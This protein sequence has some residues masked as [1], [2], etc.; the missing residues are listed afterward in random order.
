[1]N[2]KKEK[3]YKL[4][5]IMML[6]LGSYS[7]SNLLA[8]AP[9][10]RLAD[11]WY[12]GGSLGQSTLDPDSG[13]LWNI[14]NDTGSAKKL[15]IGKDISK[16]IGLEAF[17]ADL[18]NVDFKSGTK[19]GSINYSAIGAN[20][21]YNSP[22]H[23]FRLRPLGKIGVA[24]FN[25]KSKGDVQDK[26]NNMLTLFGGVGAEY[27]LSENLSLRSEF[28]Y[29][30]EDISLLSLGLNWSPKYRNHYFLDQNQKTRRPATI[31][32][33]SPA[34]NR[35]YSKNISTPQ[36]RAQAQ[37]KTVQKTLSGGSHFATGSAHLSH[38]GQFELDRL[39]Q[40]LHRKNINIQGIYVTGH[41]DNVGE[42]LANQI[43]SFNRANAVAYFL[44]SRGINQQ[45]IHTQG[46]GASQA[47]ANN[48][49][50]RG[51]AQNRRVE[52]TVRGVSP[53]IIKQ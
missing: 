50:E 26:Q 29:F 11:H 38:Q 30:A 2:M 8:A 16:Q 23:Y 15:Y 12:V 44:V 47:I 40:D 45:I 19:S 36:K 17:W 49:S 5:V 37:V 52:I 10:G 32:I 35:S 53:Q 39:A 41:T 1:M 20:I 22:Y 27:D 9:L 42:P 3:Q 6:S 31:K 18:G 7:F 46:R 21:V 25:T 4:V 43:L 34:T 33:K 51:R 14:S 24:K 48:R 28:E 13:S